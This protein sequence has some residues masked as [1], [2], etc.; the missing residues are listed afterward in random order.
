[1]IKKLLKRWRWIVAGLAMLLIGGVV[2]GW[3]LLQHIPAWYRPME[4][5]PGELQRVRNDLVQT[6]DS[7][8]EALKE[9]RGPFKFR[10]TQ[11]HVNAWLSAREAIDPKT[12]E[13]L[14]PTLS[15]P[16]VVFEPGGVRLG[17]TY[18]EGSLRAVVSARLALTA[19][20]EGI[21]ARLEDVAGGSLG[22]PDGM[23][24]NGL[25]TFDRR[26]SPKLNEA[27]VTARDRRL[28]LRDLV[29]G[30]VVP[31]VGKWPGSGQRFRVLGLD[32]EDGALTVTLE[33]LPYQAERRSYQDAF[34]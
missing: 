32:F 23:V 25:K 33:R 22:L 19:D 18:T 26:V 30:V 4:I 2:T 17:A 20:G 27:G 6:S 11:D 14:P 15:E 16:M 24:R 1:V 28:R 9:P 5:P 12:R 29:D 7:L 21:K 8:A 31:N 13:W 10:V 3:L 34:R